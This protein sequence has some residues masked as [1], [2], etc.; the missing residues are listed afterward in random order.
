VENLIRK[1]LIII[2]CS[3]TV[4]ISI[5]FFSYFDNWVY[6]PAFPNMFDSIFLISSVIFLGALAWKH[7]KAG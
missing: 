3:G 5:K 1:L 7:K 6:F 4:S 2:C